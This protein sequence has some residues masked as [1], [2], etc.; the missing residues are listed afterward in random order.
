MPQ[1]KLNFAFSA[2]IV[3]AT[4]TLGEP[5]TQAQE[6]SGNGDD[7]LIAFAHRSDAN[8]DGIYTCNEWKLFM[9]RIFSKA[10]QNHDGFIETR[11]F[12][13][14]QTSDPIFS[15]TSLSYFDM[16]D[17]RRISPSELVDREN[18]FFLRYD[19]NRDCQV[20]MNE[21]NDDGRRSQ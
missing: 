10:D 2:L 18:P 3:L 9:R 21:L 16:D 1:R 20:T 11:E 8:R 4:I 14:I 15:E 5:G 6:S 7:P 19:A 13:S 12:A 17:D